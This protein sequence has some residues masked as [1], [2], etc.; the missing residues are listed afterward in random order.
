MGQAKAMKPVVELRAAKPWLMA[1]V[2]GVALVVPYSGMAEPKT[3]TAMAHNSVAEYED[4]AYLPY[5]NP[6]APKGGELSLA[7]FGT[8]NS[9]NN[10]I[11]TGTPGAGSLYMYDTLLTGSLN[12]AFAM[13]PLLA[14]K[15]TYDPED[16]SWI[17]Y[18][19]DPRAKFWDGSPVTSEDVKATYD[20]ILS[21]GLMRWRS[22]LSDIERIE[23]PDKQTVKF[24]FK[25]GDNK[26]IGLIV[27]QLPILQKADMD[28]RFEEVSLQPLMGSGPY[29]VGAVDAGRSITY[30]RDPNYWGNDVMANIGRNNFDKVKFVYYQSD[31]IAFEGF[32]SGQ[33]R[34]RVENKARNWATAYDFPAVKAGQVVKESIHD[35]NPLAMQG[36]VMNLRRPLFQD[37]RVRQALTY[38][39]DFEWMNKTLFYDQYERLQSFFYNSELEATGTPSE[40]EMAVLQPLLAELEPVQRQKVLEEWQLPKSDGQGFNREGLLKAR[41]LLLEAGFY[42]ED[43]KLYQPNGKPAKLSVLLTGERMGRVVLPYVRNLQRLGFDA[44]IRMVDAPQYL[45]LKRSFDYDMTTDVFAQSQSPG[46]EQAYMWGSEA[47]DQ[48]GNRNSIGIKNPAIDKVISELMTAD[49]REEIILYTKVLDRLLRAGYYLVP[50]YGA[51]GTNVAY[52]KGY[53]HVEKLPTSAIGIDYWWYEDKP[54]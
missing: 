29:K 47:A 48:V 36:L 24:V 34:F 46:A 11:D 22:Y 41:E 40:A 39:F 42:Y 5:A 31:E 12:E 33:Y 52:W 19:L 15:V 25:S 37:I 28:A 53:E 49:S 10:M 7:A 14:N 54:E 6:D 8:F 20:T 50:M 4:A 13:Y 16:A 32:K 45:E 18:H 1:A 3:V 26:E 21:K 17:I 51:T 30:V 9:L 2:V 27:A 38:A 35:E 43:M 44:D 23:T